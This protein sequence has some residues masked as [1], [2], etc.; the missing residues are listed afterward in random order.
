[1][2]LQVHLQ[3]KRLK[4]LHRASESKPTWADKLLAWASKNH[5]RVEVDLLKRLLNRNPIAVE[6]PHKQ[7][8][9]ALSKS[10]L[11]V[12]SGGFAVLAKKERLEKVYNNAENAENGKLKKESCEQ[13]VKEEAKGKGG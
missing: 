7:S 12:I 10:G 13:Q 8:I 3:K 5:R 9:K 11:V 4:R 6:R 1:M 2:Y